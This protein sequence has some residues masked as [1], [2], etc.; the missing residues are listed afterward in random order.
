MCSAYSISILSD[1]LLSIQETRLYTS[2]PA[3]S[4]GPWGRTLTICADYGQLK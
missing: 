3:A 4:S 1:I 2:D